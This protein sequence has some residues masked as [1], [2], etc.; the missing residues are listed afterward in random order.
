MY[1]VRLL[2]WQIFIRKFFV[3]FKLSVLV[4]LMATIVGCSQIPVK[5][6]AGR[7]N[8]DYSSKE[9]GEPTHKVIGLVASEVESPQL[10]NAH[11]PQN[12]FMA[13]AL[14][15]AQQGFNANKAY[16]DSYEMQLMTALNNNFESIL[17]NKGFN[18]KG[19]FQTFDDIAYSDKKSM[20]LAVVPRLN[21]NIVQESDGVSCKTTHCTDIGNIHITGEMLLKVIEPLTG[22]SMLNKRI[23]LSDF[24]ILEPYR[25]EWEKMNDGGLVGMALNEALKPEQLVDDSEKALTTALSVFYAKASAKVDTFLSRDEFLSMEPDVKQL[26]DLKRY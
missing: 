16:G 23:N 2:A 20:Y 18:T 19:P 17:T 8:F 11:N 3:Q 24:N 26:K 1:S 4:I 12:P 21:L 22:Q 9:I 25:K 15:N 10:A 7:L 6:E 13:L 5:K 14:A